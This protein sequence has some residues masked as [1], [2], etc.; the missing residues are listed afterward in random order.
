MG[1]WLSSG[2]NR[3]AYNGAA[4]NANLSPDE[5]IA[6]TADLL[7]WVGDD[8]V[9]A[10]YR[11]FFKKNNYTAFHLFVSFDNVIERMRKALPHI[12]GPHYPPWE[13]LFTRMSSWLNYHRRAEDNRTKAC[14]AQRQKDNEEYKR[15]ADRTLAH[16]EALRKKHLDRKVPVVFSRQCNVAETARWVSQQDAAFCNIAKFLEDECANAHYLLGNTDDL[17]L[18]ESRLTGRFLEVHIG[19][20]EWESFKFVLKAAKEKIELAEEKE[21][22][23][24]L[25]VM[26]CIVK[27]EHF[28]ASADG[29]AALPPTGATKTAAADG[30]PGIDSMNT[31]VNASSIASAAGA[32]AG[33]A[34]L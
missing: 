9:Y 24:A 30:A 31:D 3:R 12:C 17:A 22:K 7:E 11:E 8:P 14:E 29:G 1:N 20:V 16:E 33:A 32:G 6:T 26:P 19:V 25:A 23:G 13:Q 4:S 15:L 34:A 21:A 5:Y 10:E 2:S 18:L 27:N 28:A